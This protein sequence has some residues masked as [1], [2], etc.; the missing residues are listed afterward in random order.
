MRTLTIGDIHGCRSALDYLLEA[1]S[2]RED[3]VIVTLGDYVDRGPDSKGVI[4]R[5]LELQKKHHLIAL[6]GNHEVMMLQARAEMSPSGWLSV[7]GD[8]TLDSYGA[9]V[10]SD[11]PS[12]HWQFL[13]KTARYHETETH[14]FVHAGIYPGV[15]M[16]SQ[17][18]TTL[19]WQFFENPSRHLSGK[20][21]VCGHSEVGDEPKNLEHS[22]C[23]DTKAYED[24]WLTCLDVGSGQYWQAKES[25]ETRTDTI[26]ACL[27]GDF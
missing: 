19:F 5:L 2:L 12:G 27:E 1:V 16:A 25:G 22:I 20:I 14:I 4:E 23:I 21:M 17:V 18:D 7:G 24:G 3:D 8:T 6:K 11:I 10:W 26:S 15:E 13:E 9:K